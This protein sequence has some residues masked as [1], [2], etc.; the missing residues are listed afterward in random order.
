MA[1]LEKESKIT[2]HAWSKHSTSMWQ[3]K[4]AGHGGFAHAERLH[5]TATVLGPLALRPGADG[6]SVLGHGGF[7]VSPGKLHRARPQS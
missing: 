6:H 5:T 2:N 4:Q 3:G 7:S 1:R